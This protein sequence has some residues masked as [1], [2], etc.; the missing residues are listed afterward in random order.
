MTDI[1]C[2][3]ENDVLRVACSPL[4]A[5]LVSVQKLLPNGKPMDVL[6]NGDET[7]WKGHAPILFPI[8]GRV[9]NGVYRYR[10][11]V[12]AIHCPH[13][14]LQSAR[15]TREEIG[16]A[17]RMAFVFESNNTTLIQYPFPFRFRV[18]YSLHE[19]MLRIAFN[20]HNTGTETMPFS[21]GFH[22][23]FYVPIEPTERFEDCTLRF[24]NEETP[25]QLLLDDVWMSGQSAPFA[26]ADRRMLPLRR[27]LFANDAVILDS[28]QKRIVSLCNLRNEPYL[29]LDYSGFRYLALWQ[30]P[31]GESP[32]LCL[33]TWNGLPDEAKIDSIDI[34]FKPE[35]ILLNSG[36]HYTANLSFLFHYPFVGR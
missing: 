34:L 2:L 23:G 25:Q 24:E 10:D 33:E 9:K 20:I 31:R 18:E 32:F 29:T 16:D 8:V 35:M 12:Y 22:P 27:D 6:W 13:G 28:V 1:P 4:G 5:E 19:N 26:L 15:F 17:H 36:E 3:I 7:Y 30:P 11:K 14:F 21:L